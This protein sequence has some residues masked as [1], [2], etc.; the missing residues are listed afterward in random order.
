[1]RV[2][3]LIQ[4]PQLRGAEIFACQ[5]SKEF[6]DNGTH[7]DVVYL[8]END[9]FALEFDLNFISLHANLNRRL[10]DLKAYKRLNKI[11]RERGYDI[12]QANAADTL[13]YVVI[14][15]LLFGW[16]AKI[17]F[18]NASLMGRLMHSAVHRLYNRWLLSKCDQIISVSENCR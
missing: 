6:T 11:I 5:L 13:K 16:K 17:I 12:V 8:F 1:M 2:L 7:V 3:Q 15:K 18:R 4:K 10:W 9:N 14:S